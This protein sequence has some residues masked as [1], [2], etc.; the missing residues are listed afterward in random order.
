MGYIDAE[1]LLAAARRF[2]KNEYGRY[3]ETLLG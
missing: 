3:L 2:A 1:K